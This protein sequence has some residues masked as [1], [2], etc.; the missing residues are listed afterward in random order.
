M[1]S[2]LIYGKYLISSADKHGNSQVIPNGALYQVDGN[3]LD[4]GTISDLRRRYSA[5]E[6]IGS[7]GQL[8]I[9]GL[10]N[11]HHHI[12]LTPFQLGNLDL[13]LETWIAERRGTR[14]VDPYL[15]TLYCA[16]QMIESGIT[17]VMHNGAGSGVKVSGP[18]DRID[19]SHQVLK[20]YQDSGMRVAF[21]PAFRNQNQIVY[22]DDARFLAKLPQN[23][24]RKLRE[25]LE[26]TAVSWE[27]YVTEFEE[28]FNL[29]GRNEQERIRILMAPSNVQ[30]CSDAALQGM[31]EAASRY[32]TGLHIHL[33][34]SIYQKEY[35]V[36]AWGTTPLRHLYDLGFLGPEVSC[37]HGVW[38]TDH[39]ID[40][41]AE[42]GTV[43]CH[44]ASSNLRLKSGIA[45]VNRMLEKGVTVAVGIDEAGINDDNDI[46]QE[47]RLV[48]KIHREPYV[49][50]P[51]PSSGQVLHMTTEGGATA[52]LFG[53]QLG[54]LAVGKK[55]DAV[56]VDLDRLV[57][58]YLDPDTNIVDA[59]L[60]RG[61]GL[62]VS[63]VVVAGEVL[64]RNRVLT[65]VDKEEII[66]QL[67]ESLAKDLTPEE[68][69]RKHLSLEILPHVYRFYENWHHRS[70]RPHYL[71]NQA[72]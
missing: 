20:A 69:A 38:L 58:P 60:Y 43:I 28:I 10:I 64:L 9:P 70:G 56:L 35:G 3:I 46:L 1:T 13:P 54:S 65:R 2:S 53:P 51:D 8:V 27:E 37:A 68:L 26:R 18:T 24:A 55:A 22:E 7:M 30:W 36:R 21:S 14:F 40:L 23:L 19:H 32:K 6:E 17:T 72:E 16:V 47:M 49:T 50:G 59:L 57:E 44:N 31:K 5:D 42:T 25:E 48:A 52:T 34:E 63:T 39:D 33:M 29:H 4:I 62:D 12:G 15:D 61:R 67:K 11:A 66:V 71:L 45:P 41:L